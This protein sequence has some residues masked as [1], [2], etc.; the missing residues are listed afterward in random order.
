MA[1]ILS[2]NFADE[3]DDEEEFNPAPAGDSDA[4]DAGSGDDKSDGA[5]HRPETIREKSK[6]PG[7]SRQEANGDESPARANGRPAR[8]EEEEEEEDNGEDDEGEGEDLNGDD[9]EE[10][11]EDEDEDDDIATVSPMSAVH[12]KT[13]LTKYSH[14]LENEG[15]GGSTNSSK[16]RPKSMKTMM[17]LKTTRRTSLQTVS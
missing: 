9:D 10:D 3:E 14:V 6:T 17:M 5:D 15:A 2:Q 1:S 11:E 16:R 7:V 8:D 13:L 12:G 4:E